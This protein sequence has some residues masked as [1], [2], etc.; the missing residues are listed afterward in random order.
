MNAVILLE[1]APGFQLQI[2]DLV[3]V[4]CVDVDSFALIQDPH[5]VSNRLFIFQKLAD[6]T[7]PFAVRRGIS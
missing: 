1:T 2:W 7:F 6:F 4:F 5:I 3:G